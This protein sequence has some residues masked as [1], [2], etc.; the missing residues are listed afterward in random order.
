MTESA[1]NDLRKQLN[2]ELFKSF[3][4]NEKIYKSI[5]D[6]NLNADGLKNF[7]NERENIK[8][9]FKLQR[10]HLI[11][12]NE[13]RAKNNMFSQQEELNLVKTRFDNMKNLYKEQRLLENKEYKK[14]LEEQANILKIATDTGRRLSGEELKRYQQLEKERLKI[15]QN[16]A[17]EQD[18]LN[19]KTTGKFASGLK[20]IGKQLVN[21]FI[22]LANKTTDVMYF[23]QAK[24]GMENMS[25][26]YEQNFTSI[27]GRTGGSRSET[28]DMFVDLTNVINSNNELAK[29]INIANEAVPELVNATNNGFM[30]EEAIEIAVTNAADK[31]IMPWLETNSDMWSDLQFNLSDSSLNFIKGQQLLLQESREG[32]RLLQSGVISSINDTIAPMLKSMDL[33]TT[34][35]EDLGDFYKIAEAQLG[36]GATELEIKTLAQ[37]LFDAK[38]K[39]ISSIQSGNLEQ[40]TRA[41]TIMNGGSISDA[42][43][44][45]SNMLRSMGYGGDSIVM[46][47]LIAK[48]AGLSPRAGYAADMIDNS[49]IFEDD[50]KR[51][52]DNSNENAE[53]KYL[54]AVTNV[55]DTITATAEYDNKIQNDYAERILDYLETPHAADVVMDVFNEVKEIKQAL[56][57]LLASSAID[58]ITNIANSFKGG[59]GGL[60]KSVVSESADDVLTS[61]STSMSRLAGGVRGGIAGTVGGAIGA[62]MG[63]N[64]VATEVDNFTTLALDRVNA[65]KNTEAYNDYKASLYQNAEA[66]KTGSKVLGTVGMAGGAVAGAA[67]GSV[68]PGIGTVIGG[69]VGGVIGYFGS[70]LGAAAGDA[71]SPLESVISQASVDS[72]NKLTILETNWDEEILNRKNLVA[73]MEALE[74]ETDI[75]LQKRLL[76]DAGIDSNLVNM[77]R[78]DEELDNLANQALSTAEAMGE[79]AN[80]SSGTAIEASDDAINGLMEQI[81][82]DL[83]SSSDPKQAILDII[84]SMDISG[85]EKKEL[86]EMVEDKDDWA[87]GFTDTNAREMI[88]YL[89][90]YMNDKSAKNIAGRYNYEYDTINLENLNKLDTA[91]SNQDKEAAE[92]ALENL[93]GDRISG[94]GYSTALEYVKNQKH[95]VDELSDLGIKISQYKLG[96]TYIPYDQIAL[97][98]SGE[99][100][101][102]AGQNEEYTR[103]QLSGS[104]VSS[105]IQTGVQDLISTINNQTNT[106]IE[107]L[108]TLSFNSKLPTIDNFLTP[109]LNNHRSR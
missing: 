82:S 107:Y 41:M 85:S 17:E 31:K 22:D 92:T 78:T 77:A 11:E 32:N 18:K 57:G 70:K 103:E 81:E 28:H 12:L 46:N 86:T 76:I 52:N 9:L 100:V 45:S 66:Q 33:K 89:K 87:A 23:D 62:Y 4:E 21:Y 61:S 79:L 91:I 51:L 36:K 109:R 15:E 8:K 88:P 101:L 65:A 42:A 56:L 47:E 13:I 49:L 104:T 60:G 35:K 6:K 3:G 95:Y 72:L 74:E 25:K 53:K 99:R 44:A 67:I 30:G 27:A 26:A 68:I 2:D 71:V 96:S 55:S 1:M 58:I 54:N 90:M 80:A 75:E 38:Y 84:N 97:L 19:E 5:S 59:K 34:R 73:S 14:K 98:H 64:E 37:E 43:V 83:L 7:E 94:S 69:L 106:I 16:I 24:A 50:L 93:R 48:S 105:I 20:S 63:Y 108:S 10:S 102:T 40:I 29:S 39:P